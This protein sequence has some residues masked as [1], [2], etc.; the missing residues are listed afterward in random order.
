MGLLLR[1]S[2][3]GTLGPLEAEGRTSAPWP[4]CTTEGTL[5]QDPRPRLARWRWLP[6]PERDSFREM[7]IRGDQHIGV[8]AW[9]RTERPST[10]RMKARSRNERQVP[11]AVV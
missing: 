2:L 1:N 6:R 3:S 4:A 9:S 11:A 8:Q 7:A 10:V 5:H